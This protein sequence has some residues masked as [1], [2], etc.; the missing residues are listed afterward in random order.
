MAADK[1]V[2]GLRDLELANNVEL[3]RLRAILDDGG[4]SAGENSV[5]AAGFD[6]ASKPVSAPWNKGFAMSG[7][8]AGAPWNKGFAMSGKGVKAPKIDHEG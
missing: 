7:K 5:G 1:K 8:N 3:R 6:M 2:I 4:R